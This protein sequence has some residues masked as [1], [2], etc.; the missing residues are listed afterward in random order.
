MHKVLTYSFVCNPLSANW[1]EEK[2]NLFPFPDW[3]IK[4]PQISKTRISKQHMDLKNNSYP[5]KKFRCNPL[6]RCKLLRLRPW[7]G[8]KERG[9]AYQRRLNNP[10]QSSWTVQMP[11]LLQ[12]CCEKQRGWLHGMQVFFSSKTFQQSGH[13]KW[14]RNLIHWHDL[15]HSAREHQKI[16]LTLFLKGV[17]SSG[18]SL[19]SGSSRFLV[20]TFVSMRKIH[21]YQ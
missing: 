21:Y 10:Q 17:K 8:T 14:H 4:P 20:P 2:N 13:K 19:S 16:T 1:W 12:L 6:V 9:A 18:V 11:S 5:N 15:K 7:V 3:V